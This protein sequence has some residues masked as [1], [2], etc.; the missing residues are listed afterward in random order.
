MTLKNSKITENDDTNNKEL[1]T[2]NYKIEIKEKKVY[3]SHLFFILIA[4][5]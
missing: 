3:T 4:L 1:Y 2:S 5:K